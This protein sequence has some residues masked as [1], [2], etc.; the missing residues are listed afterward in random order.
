MNAETNRLRGEAFAQFDSKHKDDG[1]KLW[2]QARQAA[3]KADK[4]YYRASLVLESALTLDMSR[5][6]VSERLA[7]ALYQRAV[8]ADRDH[9]RQK[10]DELIERMARYDKSGALQKRWTEPAKLTVATSPLGA[11][12]KFSATSTKKVAAKR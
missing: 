5:S 1:E 4:A 6:D 10:R 3:D 8:N 12:H 11:R 9:Q 7:E 2:A